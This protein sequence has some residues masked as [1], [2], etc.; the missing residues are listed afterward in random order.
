[1]SIGV[2]PACM[3]HTTCVPDTPRDPEGAGFPRTGVQMIVITILWPW[4]NP[5]PLQEQLVLLTSEPLL[6]PWRKLKF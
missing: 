4:T 1:M 3:A 6:Q 2:L 5:D